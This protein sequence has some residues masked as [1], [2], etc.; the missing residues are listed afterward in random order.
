MKSVWPVAV[1]LVL[2]VVTGL[3]INLAWTSETWAS[4]GVG[5]PGAFL[6]G[7]ASEANDPAGIAHVVRFARDGLEFVGSVFIRALRLVAVPIVLFSIIVGVA[8]LGHPRKLGALGLKT[9]A[10]YLVTA[11]I[12]VVVGLAIANVV[13]P[14]DSL[15]RGAAQTLLAGA[16]TASVQAAIERAST[17]VSGWAMILAMVPSNPFDALSRG[18]MLQVIVLAVIIGAGLTLLPEARSKPVLD[19]CSAL[20]EVCEMVVRMVMRFAPLAVFC[21]I[22]PVVA[23]LGGSALAGLGV[24]IACVVGGLLFILLAVYAPLVRVFGG[25]SP[26]AFYKGL[27][28]AQAIAFTS[29]SSS[30]TLPVT[31]R[32]VI[33]RLGVPA[34]VANFVC[35]LGATINMDGTALYQ[36]I[37]V[38]FIAQAMGIDLSIAQQAGLVVGVVLASIGSPGIPGGSLVFLIGL[39]TSV[40]VPAQGI[41]LILGVDR[42]LDMCRTVVN[43]AGDAVASVI[44]R[45]EK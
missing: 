19:V 28:P 32:C 38:L 42:L 35:P 17:P 43:V 37:A 6:A 14:G 22:T 40:G 26:A 16:N 9:L 20:G 33:E 10:I 29:S 39:L 27:G 21:L 45:N 36:G 23:R 5:A 8:S 41:A 4:L 1:A 24:Y 18:D 3:V 25:M 44:L 11:T 12:S 31:L 7:A 2:G 13:R 15:G 34:R 30:A